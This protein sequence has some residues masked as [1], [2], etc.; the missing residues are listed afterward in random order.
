MAGLIII[1][2]LESVYAL[3]LLINYIGFNPY[4]LSSA[5]LILMVPENCSICI[6]FP[7]AIIVILNLFLFQKTIAANKNFRKLCL[8]LLYIN[9]AFT[10]IWVFKVQYQINEG[11]RIVT[12]IER[13]REVKGEYPQN[14]DS[15]LTVLNIDNKKHQTYNYNI[16]KIN[17]Y[18]FSVSPKELEWVYYEYDLKEKKFK[19]IDD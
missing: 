6:F 14:I 3:H 18:R 1:V 11:Y 19:L 12:E 17:W 2:I 4:G 16:D 7:I 9:I 13:S 8:I 5:F 15:I 10:I